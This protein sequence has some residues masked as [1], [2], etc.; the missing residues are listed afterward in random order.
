VKEEMPEVLISEDEIQARILALATEIST[1][2]A[3]IGNLVMVGVLKGSFIFLAD[4]SRR[5]RI[6][7]HHRILSPYQAMKTAVSQ[8]VRCAWSWMCAAILRASTC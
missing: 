2:Y 8:P 5:L 3:D 1:D 7:A 6:P 4:L